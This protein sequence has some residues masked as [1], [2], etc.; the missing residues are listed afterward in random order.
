MTTKRTPT[1]GR[2]Q[3]NSASKLDSYMKESKK[4]ATG[5]FMR[6][7]SRTKTS[8]LITAWDDAHYFSVKNA[9]F[10]WLDDVT[11]AVD[12]ATVG[13]PAGLALLDILW[14]THF[15]NANLKDLVAADEAS[16]K[17]YYLSMLQICC[18]IQIMY[19]MRCYL[20]AFTES[21]T[22]PGSVSA[23]SFFSQSSFDIFVAS[24][25]EFPVPKG[26]YEIV[27]TFCTWVIKLTQEYERFTLRIPAAIFQPFNCL[28][29]LEDFEAMRHKLQVNLGGMVT[30]SK[31]YGL[32]V[33]AWRDPIKPAE[34][35]VNDVDVI[36]Y[37]NHSPFKYYDNQP[38][39]ITVSPN[40]GFLGANLTTDYSAHEYGF[41][42]TPN[43]SKIHVLASWFGTYN[44]TN[45]LY[46]GHIRQVNANTAEYYV[47]LLFC[48][49]HATS[50]SMANLGDAI[51]TDTLI[52]LHKG[53]SDNVAADFKL[54]FNG[55]NFTAVKGLDDC[56]PLAYNNQLFYGS[57]RGATETHNDLIN[58]LGRTLR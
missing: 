25:K 39:Q 26:I 40:G 24:M 52:T 49:Q 23:I 30:H 21:D 4:S 55:T 35:T 19:N 41:K 51:I 38:A 28:Y 11:S 27:D 29:D 7:F 47:N 58:Y 46:G 14:E 1:S 31:K 12:D 13:T 37:F 5:N 33:G 3:T 57:G 20:P 53:A 10:K 48:A 44:A 17:I 22:V 45:N 36:A 8:G 50:M 56:W 9:Y 43:E 34:R 54:E 32:G 18:D 16:W 15:Q 6:T 42:D 2:A